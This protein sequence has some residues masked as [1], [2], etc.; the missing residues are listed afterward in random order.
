M[1]R[2]IDLYINSAYCGFWP[3]SKIEEYFEEYYS[4]AAARA[5]Y[6]DWDE[7]ILYAVLCYDEEKQTLISADFMMLRM[8]YSR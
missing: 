3:L 1:A 8:D 4:E 7:I 6:I 5:E 2:D